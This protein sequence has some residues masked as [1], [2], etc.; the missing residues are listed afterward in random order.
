MAITYTWSFPTLTAYPQSEGQT[1]VVY[2]VHWVLTGTDGIYTGSVYGT[3]GL[4]YVAGS[5]YTPY[6]NLTE[7][8]VQSWTTTA[9]GAEQVAALEANIDAQIQQQITPTSVNLPPPWSA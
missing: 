6:A 4:T 7:A 5:P 8:Q 1:D 2:T 3:V 9:L